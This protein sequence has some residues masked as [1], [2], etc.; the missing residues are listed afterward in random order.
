MRQPAPQIR[1]TIPQR[2][3]N[4][5]REPFKILRNIDTIASVHA[6]KKPLLIL[7]LFVCLSSVGQ[8]FATD[9]GELPDLWVDLSMGA[10]LIDLF[11]ERARPDDIARVEHISQLDLLEGVSAGKKLVVFKSA[12]DAIRLLPHI[13]EEIDIVGYNIEH[14]PANPLFEQENPLESLQRLREAAD[15]YDLELALGPDRRFA[16]SDGVAM[17]PYADYFILQVQKVQTEPD[18]VYEFVEPLIKQIRQA[19]PD[20]EISL[21]IRTEGDVDQLIALLSPLQHEIQGISVL[22]SEETLPVTEEII[23]SLR[24]QARLPEPESEPLPDEVDI[25]QSVLTAEPPIDPAARDETSIVT[26]NE[27]SLSGE[28]PLAAVTEVP[29]AAEA[30]ERTGSTILFVVIAIVVGFAIGAGYISHRT[31]S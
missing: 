29:S 31:G 20:I 3:V 14:G 25:S 21:Q 2:V 15:T 1:L 23:K 6:L 13:H 9:N 18:T 16:Q 7:L 5:E 26:E 12:A 24:P 28:S 30:N 8:V 4:N 10:P 19:N 22:T 11:N 27:E 17:A